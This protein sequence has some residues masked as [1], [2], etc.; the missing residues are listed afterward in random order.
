VSGPTP[1]TAEGKAIIES[2]AQLVSYFEEGM[3]PK[4]DW[5]IGTEHE[6]FPFLTDT[7]EPVPYF[8]PRSIKA[9]LEGLKAR[10]GW[11]GVYEGETS[12]R[13]PI[14]RAWPTFRWSRA[15]SSSCP[16]RRSRACM[17]PARK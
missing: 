4:A 6:K 16:A 7:L 14:P 17:T 5:R 8:G 2:K 13:S 1:E 3:K 15:D 10:F 9:L 11:D 12:L